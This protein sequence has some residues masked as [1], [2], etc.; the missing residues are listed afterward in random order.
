MGRCEVQ[1]DDVRIW[2]LEARSWKLES[3]NRSKRVGLYPSIEERSFDYVPRSLNPAGKAGA[4]GTP[5]RMTGFI[6]GDEL[7]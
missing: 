7:K 5:L 2:K 6:F 3:T 4:R 1:Y